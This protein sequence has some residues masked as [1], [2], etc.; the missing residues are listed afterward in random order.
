[1]TAIT[2]EASRDMSM[3]PNNVGPAWGAPP[4]NNDIIVDSQDKEA[5]PSIGDNSESPSE[6]GDNDNSSVKSVISS[7]SNSGLPPNSSAPIDAQGVGSKAN[8]SNSAVWG[9]SF[10][11]D[12]HSQGPWGASQMS[13]GWGGPSSY[14]SSGER[15]TA[16]S[17]SSSMSWGGLPSLESKVGGGWQQG[18]TDTS[19]GDSSRPPSADHSSG[20][21]SLPPTG[22]DPNAGTESWGRPSDKPPQAWGGSS[23][24]L[25]GWGQ[26]SGPPPQRW[27]ETAGGA[28]DGAASGWGSSAGSK[29]AGPAGPSQ[30]SAGPS[31]GTAGPSMGPGGPSMGPSGPSMGPGATGPGQY[32]STWAQAACKGLPQT[33]MKSLTPPCEPPIILNPKEQFIAQAIN[34]HEGWGKRPI[35]QDTSW[36]IE[37]SPRQQ[38]RNSGSDDGSHWPATNNNG[39]AIWEVSKEGPPDW[40]QRQQAQGGGAS[41]GNEWVSDNDHGTWQNPPGER[42]NQWNRPPPSGTEQWGQPGVGQWGPEQPPPPPSNMWQGVPKDNNHWDN[43]K[44]DNVWDRNGTER[45]NSSSS[46]HSDWGDAGTAGDKMM[47]TGTWSSRGPRRPSSWEQNSW[48]AQSPPN[49]RRDGHDVDDGTSFWGKPDVPKPMNWAGG[50]PNG[51]MPSQMRGMPPDKIPP[52]WAPPPSSRNWADQHAMAQAKMEDQP[53]WMQQVR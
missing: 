29:P 36:E 42:Q 45:W 15:P 22:P 49:Q 6:A 14:P 7:S 16:S 27:G 3:W 52:M 31:A 12:I 1:M 25:G 13:M 43:P 19:W 34:S 30:L 9:S 38:R 51:P 37:D 50:P 17:A 32:P 5:W 2:S 39:T 53:V 35:R 47:E 11:S 48:D 10:A 4:P 46:S 8:N 33:E 26:P 21:G 20:W 23:Q 44:E 41:G 28:A 40:Q 24:A 18:S